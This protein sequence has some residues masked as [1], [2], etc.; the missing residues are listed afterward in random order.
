MSKIID[1]DLIIFKNKTQHNDK[2]IELTTLGN[3]KFHFH[4]PILLDEIL[5]TNNW[6]LKINEEGNLCIQKLV[7]GSFLN[8]LVLE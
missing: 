6:K 1:G 4:K 7:D 3:K 5:L 2:N 8:K